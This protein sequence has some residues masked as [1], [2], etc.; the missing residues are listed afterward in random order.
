M[1]RGAVLLAAALAGCGGRADAGAGPREWC[2]IVQVDVNLPGEVTEASGAAMDPRVPG[3]IWTHDDSGG[4]P[5]LYAMDSYGQLVGRV[6]LKG[7]KNQ[8][9][10]DLAVF[11]CGDGA[12]AYAADIGD[13]GR[14]KQDPL[15]L[16]RARLPLPGGDVEV[17]AER[18]E[19]RFPGGTRDAEAIFVT[20]SGELYLINKGQKD[21]IVLYRWP[22][23]LQ[24]GP[25]ELI[26][27][28]TLAPEV[29]QFGD[30]V[31]GAG[32]TPDGK[33]VAVRTYGTLALYRME[34]LLGTG[35]PAFTLDLAPLGESQGEGVAV[36][37]TGA[38]LL[39]SEG[40]RHHVPAKGVWLRCMLPE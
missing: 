20:P 8:D 27:V 16:Y 2:R 37:S 13:N 32:A 7:A 18:F 26:P 35:G 10:E 38:V 33:W 28:R 17:P 1:R 9:W 24:K 25:V 4:E 31:T 23:P 5:M 19:A 11:R 30:R 21:P 29:A 40:G 3:V 22:T 15:V 36:D 34:D 6:K 12:C 39:V 14:K